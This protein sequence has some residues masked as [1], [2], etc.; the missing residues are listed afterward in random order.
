MLPRIALVRKR[1][2]SAYRYPRLAPVSQYQHA[3]HGRIRQRRAAGQMVNT[4]KDISSNRTY[5][6]R[7]IT[8]DHSPVRTNVLERAAQSNTR[9]F[10]STSLLTR[11][12]GR[13]NI[14]SDNFAQ[15]EL[16]KDIQKV[17]IR[18]LGANLGAVES[19]S[20]ANLRRLCAAFEFTTSAA[21]H[22]GKQLLRI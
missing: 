11:R 17:F 12:Q 10:G 18:A 8:R 6:L 2:W 3:S 20:R 19:D 21:K 7:A 4:R 5:P 15:A 13:H 16:R 22:A 9:I 1:G 14:P